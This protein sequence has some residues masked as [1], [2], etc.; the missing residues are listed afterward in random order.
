MTYNPNMSSA[1]R[2]HLSAADILFDESRRRDVAGYLYG[3]AAECAIKA[4]MIEAG[5]RPIE[6][7]KDD[8]LFAHFPQLRTSLRDCQFGRKGTTL[9]RFINNDNFFSQWDIK[10]RYCSGSEIDGKWIA[11]WKKQASDAVSSI[12]T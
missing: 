4:M 5:H 11:T 9:L 12:G 6:N 1:A 10:M 8:P 7:S 3:I 2:R